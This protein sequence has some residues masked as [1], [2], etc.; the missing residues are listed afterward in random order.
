MPAPSGSVSL[1]LELLRTTLGASATF[2]TWTGAADQSAAE[3]R[4]YKGALPKPVSG[5]YSHSLAELQTLRPYAIIFE[6]AEEGYA[7]RAVAMSDSRVFVSSGSFGILLEWDI[8]SNISND[9]AE[10]AIQF[11]NTYGGII[12][13]IEAPASTAGFLDINEMAVEDGPWRSH[14]DDL[15]IYGDVKIVMLRI[16][17]GIQQ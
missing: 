10:I 15:E 8:P 1:A 13:A 7:T 12:D 4:I 3:A 14:E 9:P 5:K 17:W 11:R 2:R 6:Q 16:S